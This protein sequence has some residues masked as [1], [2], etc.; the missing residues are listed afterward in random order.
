MDP[1]K[2]FTESLTPLPELEN[3]RGLL[4]HLKSVSRDAA[5]LRVQKMTQLSSPALG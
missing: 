4:S 5:S 3:C 2:I 1:A